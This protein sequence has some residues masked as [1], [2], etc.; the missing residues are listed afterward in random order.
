M[1]KSLFIFTEIT[2]ILVILVNIN[3]DLSPEYSTYGMHTDRRK[4]EKND[5]K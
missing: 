4:M 3:S 1:S 5:M 2:N